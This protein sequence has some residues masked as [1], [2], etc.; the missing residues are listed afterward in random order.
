MCPPV[1]A[2]AWPALAVPTVTFERLDGIAVFPAAPL[3]FCVIVIE[4]PDT[5]LTVTRF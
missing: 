2:P 3:L 5:A 4:V 1:K